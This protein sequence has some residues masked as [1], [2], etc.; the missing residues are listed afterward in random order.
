MDLRWKKR[1]KLA[2]VIC[3]ERRSERADEEEAGAGDCGPRNHGRACRVVKPAAAP[4]AGRKITGGFPSWGPPLEARR[5][6]KRLEGRRRVE[7][8]HEGGGEGSQR[9]QLVET[10]DGDPSGGSCGGA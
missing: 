6:G 10:P 5:V 7:R 4:G 9:R 8:L 1:E 3:R 2:P